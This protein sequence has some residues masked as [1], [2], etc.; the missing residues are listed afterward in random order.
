MIGIF[1]DGEIDSIQAIGNGQSLYYL[2]DDDS[3]YVGMDLTE[4]GNIIMTFKNR[5]L[6]KVIWVKGAKG[7]T[8]PFNKIPEDKRRLKNFRWL[9][10]IRPKSAGEL[11][12]K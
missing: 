10:A 3:A 5:E 2:Q 1:K 11:F 6:K 9:E 7:T 4:A 12:G 8:Y